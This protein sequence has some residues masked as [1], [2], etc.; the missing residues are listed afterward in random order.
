MGDFR[1]LTVTDL[2]RVSSSEA[3]KREKEPVIV[4]LDNIRSM[5]NIGSIFRTCD[6]FSIQKMIL[7]GFTAQPPHREIQKTAL[8]ATESVPWEYIDDASKILLTL[9][10]DGYKLLAIE[11]TENST[12]LN[13]CNWEKWGPKNVLILGNEI[14]GVMQEILNI[15]D[16]CIEI[17][18]SGA[19]HSFNVT[20][21]AGIVLYERIFNAKF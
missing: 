9:K 7:T 20:I 17:P 8:G 1:K 4:M 2:K 16:A 21:A 19:K 5:N 12:L 14:N 11:Q 13:N 18:Q 15:C 6:A 3:L 10:D